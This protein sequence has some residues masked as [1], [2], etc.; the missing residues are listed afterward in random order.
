MKI[1][2]VIILANILIG[3]S[4]SVINY[5]NI[6]KFSDKM[7]TLNE[8]SDIDI[9]NNVANLSFV[10]FQDKDNFTHSQVARE[11]QYLIGGMNGYF[12]NAG[13]REYR[14]WTPSLKYNYHQ[15]WLEYVTGYLKEVYTKIAP[16][17]RFSSY[18][19]SHTFTESQTLEKEYIKKFQNTPTVKVGKLFEFS[20]MGYEDT[21]KKKYSKTDL[22]SYYFQLD[23]EMNK[24]YYTF[25][26][27]SQIVY[28]KYS[29]RYGQY[30]N[31]SLVYDKYDSNH[32]TYDYGFTSKEPAIG[33]IY[34]GQYIFS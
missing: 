4:F 25:V 32:G 19:Q 33:W 28:F 15:E 13:I 20:G 34:T 12:A 7:S 17:I 24:G 6:D 9:V 26:G 1:F 31:G 21:T 18:S 23:D 3:A 30:K 29:N 27:I 5:A 2:F 11:H 16:S 22:S 10:D 8:N 14:M